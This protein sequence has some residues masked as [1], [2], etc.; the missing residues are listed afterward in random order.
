ME[1]LACQMLEIDY[2][3][4]MGRKVTWEDDNRD[5]FPQDWYING[6]YKKKTIILNEA[7][8]KKILI[9][10]TDG[11]QDFVEGVRINR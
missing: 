11:Y 5:L 9:I 3:K 10:N 2:I 7:I 4:A 8:N 1:K 6:N